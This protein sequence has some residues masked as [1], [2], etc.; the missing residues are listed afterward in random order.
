MSTFIK[1]LSDIPKLLIL[2]TIFHKAYF[3]KKL[4]FINWIAANVTGLSVELLFHVQ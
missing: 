1:Y 2:L 3:K 4:S